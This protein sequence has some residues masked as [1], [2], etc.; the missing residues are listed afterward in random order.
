[1]AWTSLCCWLY[2]KA[3]VVQEACSKAQHRLRRQ[4]VHLLEIKAWNWKT[5]LQSSN[6][7]TPEPHD[8]HISSLMSMHSQKRQ[9]ERI[10]C[11]PQDSVNN[12]VSRHLGDL[13]PESSRMDVQW[14]TFSP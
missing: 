14:L 1:M 10:L 3:L 9:H 5:N 2:S 8:F 4:C 6:Q 11:A 7:Q 12:P 13:L